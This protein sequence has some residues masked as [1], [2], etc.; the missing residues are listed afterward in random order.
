MTSE[1]LNHRE[2]NHEEDGALLDAYSRSVT[3]V[4]DAVGPSVVNIEVERELPPNH[5]LR[6]QG[7]TRGPAGT[8][9]GFV[10]TP[11]GFILTNSHVV[12]GAD[13]IEITLPDGTRH[14][15][16]LVGDDPDTDLAVIRTTA[17]G[18]RAVVF[19]DSASLRPGQVVVAIG[20]PYGFQATVTAGVVSA[21]GRSFRSKSGRLVDNVIQTDAALNPGNSGGPLANSR[22]EVV[23][24]NTA[25]IAAAQ[26]ICFAVPGNTAK[27]VA[28]KLIRDGHIRRAY[29]GVAGQ[30]VPLQRKVVRFYNLTQ[31]T[32]VLVAGVEENSPA[33]RGGLVEGD[34]ILAIDGYP[35]EGV[36]SLHR[37]L[38]EERIGQVVTVKVLR[39]RELENLQVTP[40]ESGK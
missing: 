8:G 38:T 32:G 18:L 10:I 31:D 40:T 37:L 19:G 22:G 6:R 24:V 23:G 28:A 5:P 26:G 14:P 16:T 7:R 36:D 27:W 29:L 9:S 12:H 21:M 30:D 39:G 20:N 35:I 3:G 2:L 25:I 17:P 34:I 33:K 13:G 1:T 11:D 15:A 4:V